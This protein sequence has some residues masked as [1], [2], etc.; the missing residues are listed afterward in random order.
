MNGQWGGQGGGS[1]GPD[2]LGTNCPGEAGSGAGR[3][4]LCVRKGREVERVT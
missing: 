2:R 3:R 1:P 4:E